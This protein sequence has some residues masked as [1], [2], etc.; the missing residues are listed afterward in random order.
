VLLCSHLLQQ[1]QTVCDRVGLFVGG[2]L[3]ASGTVSELSEQHGG[4]LAIE[5]QATENASR[6]IEDIARGV[7]GV[8]DVRR[9]GDLLVV[10]AQDDV[11][12]QLSHA[13]GANGSVVTHLR[14]RPEELDDVYHRYFAD[15]VVA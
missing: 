8:V 3:A 12:E 6:P 1:V 13:L 4:R 7:A 11:R 2:R 9:E 10:G 14:I 5:L 15:E